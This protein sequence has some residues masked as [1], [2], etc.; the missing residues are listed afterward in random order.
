[1]RNDTTFTVSDITITLTGETRTFAT[2]AHSGREWTGE[3][4]SPVGAQSID[5]WISREVLQ[6]IDAIADDSDRA[7]VIDRLHMEME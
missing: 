4:G 2:I 6:G 5:C 7:E 3:V 1:M